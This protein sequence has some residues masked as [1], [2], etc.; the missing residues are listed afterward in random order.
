[1]EIYKK[2]LHAINK[3]RKINLNVFKLKKMDF[4]NMNFI[5][6]CIEI[7]KNVF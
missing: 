5:N 2:L 6:K 4:I 7:C 3:S 1:M